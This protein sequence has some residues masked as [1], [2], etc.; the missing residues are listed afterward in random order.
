MSLAASR[1]WGLWQVDAVVALVAA[2]IMLRGAWIIGRGAWDALM[3]RQ[4][5]ADV[6]ARIGAVADG[7][8]G[9]RAWHDLRTRTAGS[10]T[11]VILHVE[12]DGDQTLAEAHA[13][14]AALRLAIIAAVPHADVTIH[15]DVWHPPAR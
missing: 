7:F 13:I 11:F 4:A 3:D 10:R 6:I 2:A 5:G 14:G 8:P 9:V 1:Y 12:L 15:K